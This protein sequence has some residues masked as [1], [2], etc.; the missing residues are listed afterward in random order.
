MI[1]V[2]LDVMFQLLVEGLLMDREPSPMMTSI[3]TPT[4]L[5]NISIPNEKGVIEHTQS[6]EVEI[7]PPTIPGTYKDHI[8]EVDD[9]SHLHKENPQNR[10]LKHTKLQKLPHY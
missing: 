3:S 10:L 9:Y 8:Q 2:F 4:Q 5:V 6:L 1:H 7:T